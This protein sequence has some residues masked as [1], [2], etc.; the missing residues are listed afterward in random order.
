MV[1]YGIALNLAGIVLI[2]AAMFLL[3]V[4]QL[5][6]SLDAIPDWAARPA[7]SP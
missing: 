5:G 3:I 4:P 6:I 2:T 1:R 7:S